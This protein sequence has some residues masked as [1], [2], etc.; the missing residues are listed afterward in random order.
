MRYF[1]NLQSSYL[2]NTAT[3]YDSNSGGTGQPLL[4]TSHPV[5]GGTFAN[6]SSTP[7]SLNE[8]SLNAAIKAIPT[9]FVDQ[10]NM[11]IDVKP[12]KLLVPWNI[13]DVALR[14]VGAELRPGTA[15][16]D[17]NVIHDL[18]GKISLKTCRFLT[19]PYAWFLITNVKGFIEFEREPYEQDMFVDFDTD[20]LK[21]KNFER[22]GYFWLDP[23]AV[24]GQMATS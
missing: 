21:I 22:K 5:D 19:N 17:P 18:S 10:A 13:R 15:N 1:W 6:T 23:R 14:L 7:Q 12:E 24:Y 2:F 11:L 16:N 9:T 3:T 20:N 8:G 4:S